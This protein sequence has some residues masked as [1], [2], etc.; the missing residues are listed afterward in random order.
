MSNGDEHE[1]NE[2]PPLTP[3]EKKV[4]R[5]KQ[6]TAWLVHAY[7]MSG[8]VLGMAALIAVANGDPRLAFFFLV[9]SMFI[10]A[11]DGLM[12]RAIRIS[13]VLPR[14]SGAQVDNAVDVLTF[15]FVP[16][17]IIAYEGLLPHF[18][19]IAIPTMAAMYAYGQIDMKTEDNFFRG[20]PSYWNIIALYMYWLRP[21]DF[22]AVMAII[23]P[24]ILTLIPTRY[25]YPSRNSVFWKTSWSLGI[26]WFFMLL[27]LLYLPEPPLYLVLISLYYPAYYLLA[28]FYVE[29]RIRRY[30]YVMRKQG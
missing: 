11:T 19:W 17:F 18:L 12:A 4:V 2:A 9:V 14:F 22:W 24:S 13:E 1:A 15:I 29:Y 7:T 8:A 30:G 3:G 25:L 27:Y 26:L 5:R 28:S 23:V 16:L 6:T 10:D 21:D 20:F